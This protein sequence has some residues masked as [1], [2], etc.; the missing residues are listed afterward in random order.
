MRT[1]NAP[2]Q[3]NLLQVQA[4]RDRVAAERGKVV[5]CR[6]TSVA[7]LAGVEGRVAR[8]Q[9]GLEQLDLGGEREERLDALLGVL[10]GGRV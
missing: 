10:V 6:P 5:G 7:T 4:S 9:S 1:D 3:D 8:V 2:V